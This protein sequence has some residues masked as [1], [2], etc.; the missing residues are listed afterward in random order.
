MPKAVD[1]KISIV[2]PTYNEV[3]N[4]P[5]LLGRI[6]ASLRNSDISYEVLVVDDDSPDRTW[7][8]VWRYS[9]T[10]P[11]RCIRRRGERGL[12]TAVARGV[13]ESSSTIVVIMDADLQHPPEKIPL[14]ISEIRGG[15]DIAIASRF[16]EG[17]ANENFSLFRR[18]VSGGADFLAKTIFNKIR[19]IGDI[20]SGFFAIKKDVISNLDLNPKGYKILLEI[21]VLGNYSMVSEKGY[22]FDKRKSGE[23]KLGA[24]VVAEYIH[25]LWKL[26]L[27]TGE[28]HRFL[29]FCAVGLMGVFLNLGVLYLLTTS[30]GLFYLVSGAIAIETS[31]LFNF[32][33]NKA[34]TFN[35][36]GIVGARV[37]GK[38]LVKDHTV[39]AGGMI[40]NLL[41]LWILTSV[42][43]LY[44][45]LSQVV[46]IGASTL[47][48]FGGNKLWT[49]EK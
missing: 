20:Q 41:V 36:R 40:I 16:A 21:L 23:S 28:F 19:G 37:V 48:N 34:W 9:G 4:I 46:G 39:R 17:G 42:F 11:A 44:Y 31:L 12:A 30:L 1:D 24:R 47:W 15:A 22:T 32:F 3:G 26:F 43:S 38:A 49:W 2:I 13:K 5:E 18:A 6:D 35:D 7:E 14:L 27:R 45:L 33:M 29:K 10:Y 8:A 25:H